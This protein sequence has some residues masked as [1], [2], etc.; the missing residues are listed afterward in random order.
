MENQAILEGG[1]E[2]KKAGSRVMTARI[3]ADAFHA[4]VPGRRELT[5]QEKDG[6][7][8]KLE[9]HSTRIGVKFSGKTRMHNAIPATPEAL[10][11]AETYPEVMAVLDAGGYR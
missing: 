10:V 9:V 1:R 2:W 8:E 6:G 7:V 11:P 4:L 5:D 3:L